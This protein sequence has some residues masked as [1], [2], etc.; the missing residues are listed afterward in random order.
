VLDEL[1]V[2]LAPMLLGDGTRLFENGLAGSPAALERTSVI[3]SPSGVAH[4]SYR[5]LR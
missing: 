3:E 5:V 4:L 2:H 1:K